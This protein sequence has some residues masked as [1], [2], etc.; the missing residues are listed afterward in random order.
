MSCSNGPSNTPTSL[1]ACLLPLVTRRRF[2]AQAGG[3]LLAGALLAGCEFGESFDGFGQAVDFDLA[4]PALA[5]LGTVGGVAAL[6][7]GTSAF[8]LVRAAVDEVLAFD[9]KCPHLDL[10]MAGE[11]VPP[12]VQAGWDGAR[13]ELTCRWHQTVYAEQGEVL[14]GP[15]P[16]GLRRYAVAFDPASGK[17]T[18]DAARPEA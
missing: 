2:L 9:L 10:D 15:S 7:S 1:P 13:R 18:V 14:S 5:G 8:L 6:V 11:S 16:A 4:D 12:S 17:G 3:A